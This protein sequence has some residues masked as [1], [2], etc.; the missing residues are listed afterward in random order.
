MFVE[1]LKEGTS[2]YQVT[3]FIKDKLQ[4]NAASVGRFEELRMDSPW[5]L[6]FGR[7][8]F[9]DLKSSIIAFRLP[10]SEKE[11]LTEDGHPSIRITACHTDFPG[12]RIKSDPDMKEGDYGKIDT[13]VY[14]GPI[15]STWLDR[16]L[17]VS[18]IVAAASED[19]FAP[20][21]VPYDSRRALFTIPNLAIH[22]DWETNNGK[23]FNRQT[24]LIPIFTADAKGGDFREFLASELGVGK[25]EILS[26][27]LTVYNADAPELL[28]RDSDILS[29]PRIDNLS[30]VAACLEGILH[31]HDTG[32]A[33]DT[34]SDAFIGSYV[35]KC[36]EIA[37]FFNHEEIG[38][39]TGVGADS[40]LLSDVIT[41]IYESLGLCEEER[42]RAVYGGFLLSVDVAHAFHPNYAEKADPVNRPIINH[43]FAVKQAFSQSYA[44]QPEA[45]SAVR[46]ICGRNGIPCQNYFNRSDIPG[47]H[48]L[49]VFVESRLPMRAADIG[50]PIL[51]M[52]S[53]RETCGMRDYSAMEQFIEAFYKERA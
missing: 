53:A 21:L 22:M 13:E 32:E 24:Q 8:Y 35:A 28:G 27:D 25:E 29:S 15:E 44:T 36:L 9:I 51:A 6:S 16:P 46:A 49:G 47:G 43:G 7:N 1:L 41:R 52:H 12:F 20:R 11:M 30:S 34:H 39:R 2:P 4:E 19:P 26:W 42:I 3:A 37:A 40:N 38:S 5:K 17:G 33:A 45:V 50:L 18:G 10:E 23:T 48:T 31:V 14:G